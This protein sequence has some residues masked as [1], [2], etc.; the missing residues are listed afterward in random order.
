MKMIKTVSKSIFVKNKT[1]FTGAAWH[2]L[3]SYLQLDM[4]NSDGKC[5][6]FH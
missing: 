4:D 2:N 5:K 3:P 1:L 6:R